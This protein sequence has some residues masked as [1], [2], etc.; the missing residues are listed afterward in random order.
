MNRRSLVLLSIGVIAVVLGGV[1]LVVGRGGSQVGAAERKVPVLVATSAVA[2]QTSGDDL[3]TQGT[4]KVEQVP[5]ADRQPG[6]LSDP[7]QVSGRTVTRAIAEGAQVLDQDLATLPL[8]ASA[9]Q[10][11]DGTEAVAVDMAFT[12]GGAGYFAPGDR[13]NVMA[14]IDPASGG[15]SRD[16]TT[17]GVVEDVL[18]LDVSSE[19]A[20]RVAA[21]PTTT[22]ASQGQ[23]QGAAG[24]APSQL[25]YLLAVPVDQVQRLVQAAAFHRLYLSLPVEGRNVAPRT[26]VDDGSLLGAAR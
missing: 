25:T 21:R 5:A 22:D 4:L 18:V 6:A 19:V 9:I 16:R 26:A 14:L 11:P 10:V 1:A 24:A 13:V 2:T 8:R 20:P 3:V 15:A 23:S 17:V 12:A 7:S